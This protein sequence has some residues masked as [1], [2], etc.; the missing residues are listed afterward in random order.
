MA[1]N[2]F[3]DRL[4]LVLEGA[5]VS[6]LASAYRSDASLELVLPGARTAHR[7]R[8][9]IIDELARWWSA[10][11]QLLHWSETPAS[12]G[13]VV[14]SEHEGQAGT[15]VEQ[16][17][18]RHFVHIAEDLVAKHIILSERPQLHRP[19]GPIDPACA[20]VDLIAAAENPQ[21]GSEAAGVLSPLLRACAP[22]DP[23]THGGMSGSSLDRLVLPDGNRFVLK[24]LTR[25]LDWIMRATADQGREARLW[26]SG[27]L[28]PIVDVIDYPVVAAGQEDDGWVLVM[29]DVS[30]LLSRPGATIARGQSRRLLEATHVLHRAFA[31]RVPEGV[32]TLGDRYRLLSPATAK[33]EQFEPDLGPKMA[34]RSWELFAEVAP[35]DIADL[36]LRLIDDPLPLV[37]ALDERGMTLIH[38]DMKPD[39]FGFSADRVVVLDW[40]LACASPP[41]VE[42]TWLLCFAPQFEASKDE[43]IQEFRAIWADEHD[44]VA[45]QLAIIGQMV[46][47][48]ASWAPHMV[49]HP[50]EAHRKRSGEEFEWWVGKTRDAL[51][52]VAVG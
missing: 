33:R 52:V 43:L 45:L 20:A 6:R 13:L 19:G 34:Q 12:D 25:R 7:G 10:P 15:V 22:R 26:L 18:L 47:A 3:G 38:G 1:V 8:R 28:E 49:D 42:L 29:T 24:H 39:N 5:D 36:V 30:D 32:C 16:T 2:G 44:E 40:A 35:P 23:L 50:D 11:A 4:R 37:R 31:G 21:T 27:V 41:A 48:G 51:E 9:A 17:R 46:M 14:V